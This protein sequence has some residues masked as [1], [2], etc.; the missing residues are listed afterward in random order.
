M[1]TNKS[2]IAKASKKVTVLSRAEAEKIKGGKW[3]CSKCGLRD[4]GPNYHFCE[5][6]PD[7]ER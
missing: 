1:C 4:I 7:M 2:T 5:I 6:L 3:I